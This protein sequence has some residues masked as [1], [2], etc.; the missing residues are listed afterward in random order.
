VTAAS[1]RE[2]IQNAAKFTERG[3][4]LRITAESQQQSVLVRIHDNGRGIAAH[5]LL[6]ILANSGMSG[7]R[8]PGDD[9][10]GIG[11][12]L[13]KT[14]VELHGVTVTARSDGLGR[15]SEFSVRLP[16][17]LVIQPQSNQAA[18][19]CFRDLPEFLLEE[20]EVT[21]E[22]I[23]IDSRWPEVAH[24]KQCCLTAPAS[25]AS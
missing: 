22:L 19:L 9:D 18:A 3:G 14:I 15:V 23:R 10:L 8:A 4:C 17:M 21:R 12:E 6:T 1:V 16:C 20:L 2:P 24:A 13:V 5:S 25:N 7:I 11:L